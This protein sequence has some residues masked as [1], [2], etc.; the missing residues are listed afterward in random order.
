MSLAP[1]ASQVYSVLSQL[2]RKLA[3]A[4]TGLKPTLTD[5]T[6]IA[7]LQTRLLARLMDP[8]RALVLQW[9]GLNDLAPDA[10][11]DIGLPHARPPHLSGKLP[12]L[13]WWDELKMCDCCGR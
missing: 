8:E 7:A 4:K 2:L 9:P 10:V 5:Q 1:T 3:H 13:D 6:C 12:A 11:I